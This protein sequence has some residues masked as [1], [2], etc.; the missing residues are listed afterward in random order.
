[1]EGGIQGS[2]SC[3][4]GGD[5]PGC[6][7]PVPGPSRSWDS[8]EGLCVTRWGAS[9][10]CA[11]APCFSPV[12]LLCRGCQGSGPIRISAAVNGHGRGPAVL[13][14]ASDIKAV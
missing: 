7:G 3:K 1:M 10:I 6:H 14:D 12:M 2:E 5:A 9:V 11:C 4:A 8:L 13:T